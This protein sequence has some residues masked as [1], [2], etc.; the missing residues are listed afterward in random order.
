MAAFQVVVRFGGVQ[1]AAAAGVDNHQFA[2]ADT[3]L[4]D[5]FV[6]LV[7][8]DPDFRRAGDQLVFG[9]DIARRAQTV[10]VEVTGGE[11]PVGHDDTGRAVPRLHMHGVEVKE[12]A[13]IRVHIRVVLPGWRYQQTHGADDVHPA[14]QQQF[15]HV[16]H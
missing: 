4:F 13:Q 14:R 6:R 2:G 10:T 8:P 3:A 7:V 9:D 12:G 15:Q 16:I 5:H 11:T 1:N